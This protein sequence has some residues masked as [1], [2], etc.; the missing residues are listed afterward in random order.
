MKPIFRVSLC[1]LAAVLL[2]FS[3]GQY[4]SMKAHQMLFSEA[5]QQQVNLTP[6]PPLDPDKPTVVVILGDD[7]S[8]VSDVLGPYQVFAASGKYNV[9]T[10]APER[11]PVALT[12]GLDLL[13]H[14]AL[15]E[16]DQK[17]HHPPAVVVVPN[18]PFIRDQENAPLVSWLKKQ[19]KHPDTV[20]M[21]ICSGA[22]TLAL[23]GLLDGKKATG[24]WSDRSRLEKQFPQ[25][26]WT[27]D[28]RY[29]DAGQQVTS[30]GVLSGIDASLHVLKRL[31]GPETAHQTAQKM[32]YAQSTH[33]TNPQMQPFDI[34]L[35]DSIF[36]LNASYL[37]DRK[38]YQLPLKKGM[39]EIEL[40]ALVDTFP[41]TFSAELLTTA[42]V[43]GPIQSRY[44]LDL[45]PRA[46][47]EQSELEV[48]KLTGTG[49]PFDDTLSQ[50]ALTQNVPTAVFGAKRL[51]Y[52]A[53]TQHFEGRGWWTPA[54]YRPL[55]LALLG[56]V[57]V[58]VVEWGM[59]MLRKRKVSF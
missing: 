4:Q 51:E 55:Y 37:W 32:N 35:S 44:G 24:H 13:P 12:G 23:T 46:T 45:L 49:F 27:W 59:R 6:A 30:A 53:G 10:A 34:A 3:V 5:P 39:D 54:V 43:K 17:L 47:S 31:A 25:V 58:L 56:V 36:L 8:E 20:I 29:V 52:R 15:S 2:P 50:L 18:I 19:G 9:V 28:A 33:L 7:V 38:T 16:L 57:L 11:R 48:L 21:S 40:A 22:D 1:L 26:H 42:P 41:A 14:Y